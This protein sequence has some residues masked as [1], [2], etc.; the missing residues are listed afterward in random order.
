MQLKSDYRIQTDLYKAT[1]QDL[2]KMIKS[3]KMKP[4][5]QRRQIALPLKENYFIKAQTRTPTPDQENYMMKA[6]GKKTFG[7]KHFNVN[8]EDQI[9]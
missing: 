9:A 1:I 6:V 4:T 5:S 7:K 2:Q 3:L 8:E